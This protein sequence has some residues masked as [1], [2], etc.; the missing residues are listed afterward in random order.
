MFRGVAS[1]GLGASASKVISFI[2]TIVT[3]RL[4]SPEHFGLV[5]VVTAVIAFA[6]IFNHIG[7]AAAV[8]QKRRLSQRQLSSC[9]F[10]SI[11]LSILIFSVALSTR[12]SLAQFYNNDE[13]GR[14]FVLISFSLLINGF[15]VIH[16]AIIQ[17]QMRFALIAKI[18]VLAVMFQSILTITLAI[19][20]YEAWAL[21]WGILGYSTFRSVSYILS[22]CWAPSLLFSIRKSLILIKFGLSVTYTRITWMLYNK[23]DMVLV[24]KYSS[25]ID[26]G[27][28]TMAMNL[29]RL[30][31]N[32]IVSLAMGVAP[33]TFAKLKHNKNELFTALNQLTFGLTMVCF[34]L[35]FG[36]IA[37]APEMIPLLL[38]DKWADSV[39]LF[40]LIAV[41]C[42]FKC[43]DPLLTQLLISTGK[44]NIT[45]LFTTL[46]AIVIP[47]AVALGA[48]NYGVFG[49]AA[50]WAICYPLLFVF[51]LYL[52]KKHIQMKL[53]AYIA[54]MKT[55]FITSFSMYF[56]VFISGV[57]LETNL[58]LSGT[59]LMTIKILIGLAS[60]LCFLVLFGRR[61]IKQIKTALEKLGV[62]P[63]LLN[64]AFFKNI[65]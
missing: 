49:A 58:E 31:S 51:L 36:L 34:P 26:T 20:K 41:F 22:S 61:E 23:A 43:F 38:G 59:I 28:Y 48:I 11:A 19:L 53:T 40:Q 30:P 8:V 16:Y 7:L 24:G 27:Y 14:I 4:L 39:I 62:P 46:C 13:I 47:V 15:S 64:F 56:T 33:V 45:A 35:M 5:A 17:K 32:T 3:A 50:A 65:R 29:A 1:L 6:E 54:S 55:P 44:Q 63:K 52:L 57:L 12:T 10:L 9:F 2:T 21:A 37:I 60:F 18:E 25:P 42:C